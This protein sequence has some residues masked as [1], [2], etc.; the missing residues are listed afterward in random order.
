MGA[1]D[2]GGKEADLILARIESNEERFFYCGDKLVSFAKHKVRTNVM[3]EII[4]ESITLIFFY[5]Y[6][7]SRHYEISNWWRKHSV[8]KET[9]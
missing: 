6:N 1:C 4:L 5:K 2:A 9:L 8:T 7:T 3:I